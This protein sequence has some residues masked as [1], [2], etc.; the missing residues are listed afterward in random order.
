MV[1]VR[2]DGNITNLIHSVGQPASVDGNSR[3]IAATACPTILAPGICGSVYAASSACRKIAGPVVIRTADP[4]QKKCVPLAR[5]V[6]AVDPDLVMMMPT[7]MTRNPNP[8]NVT[9]VVARSTAVIR[10]VTDHD[11]HNDSICH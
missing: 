4:S 7:P 2:D 6:M 3:V 5:C 9:D 10:P 11:V 1:D 8:V